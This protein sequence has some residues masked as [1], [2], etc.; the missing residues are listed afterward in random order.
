MFVDTFSIQTLYSQLH[1]TEIG[2][3]RD[4]NYELTKRNKDMQ[5]LQIKCILIGV[6]F[7]IRNII[8]CFKNKYTDSFAH[9]INI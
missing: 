3:I 1:A 8:C 2:R 7:V 6:V 5:N 9:G 4:K